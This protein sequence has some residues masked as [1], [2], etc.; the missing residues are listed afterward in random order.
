MHPHGGSEEA[1]RPGRRKTRETNHTTPRAAG[2]ARGLLRNRAGYSLAELMTVTAMIGILATIMYPHIQLGRFQANSA[3]RSIGSV[4]MSAQRVAVTRQHDVI[5]RFHN[6]RDVVIVH[7]DLDDD[8]VKDNNEMLR[9]IPLG[10]GIVFGRGK[11]P[12]RPGV[13]GAAISFVRKSGGQK[14]VTF[15]RNG[16]ASENG[17]FYLVSPRQANGEKGRFARYLEVTRSTGRISWYHYDGQQ[18]KRGF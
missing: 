2:S 13:G 8:G 6:G 5:V 15:H 3:M 14:S 17:G 12:A 10:E 7:Y 1:M 11:A 4:L 9:S 18:W 16:S